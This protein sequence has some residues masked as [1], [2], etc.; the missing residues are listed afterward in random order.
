M[1]RINSG[2]IRG[3]LPWKVGEFCQSTLVGTLNFTFAINKRFWLGI[4]DIWIISKNSNDCLIKLSSYHLF[5]EMQCS[6]FLSLYQ[7]APLH[8]VNTTDWWTDLAS[9]TVILSTSQNFSQPSERQQ[10]MVIQSGW[11]LFRDNGR[12]VPTWVHHKCTFISKKRLNRGK[13]LQMIPINYC[14]MANVQVQEIFT[15]FANIT[16]L[17]T[18][19][20]TYF[21]LADKVTSHP[22]HNILSTKVMSPKHKHWKKKQLLFSPPVLMYCGLL[23]ITFCLGLWELRCA[24]RTCIVHHGAQG[25]PL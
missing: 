5:S 21:I 11:T 10:Q 7:T 25:G 6:G 23:G 4:T 24:P 1:F 22:V 16:L 2:I 15:N 17:P 8:P 13:M 19:L 3:K 14:K 18:L 12:N 20:H 9:R